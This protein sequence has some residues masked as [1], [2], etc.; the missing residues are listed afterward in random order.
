[1]SVGHPLPEELRA[2]IVRAF[3]DQSFTYDEIAELLGVGRATVNRIL[4]LHRETGALEPRPK[5]GGNV[6][7]ISGRVAKELRALV[8]ARPDSTLAELMLALKQRT[9]VVTSLSSM[10]RAMRRLGFSRKK[11]SSS[12]PSATRRTTSSADESSPRS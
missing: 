11:R 8:A 1:M 12:P 4:R 2:A 7:P 9:G 5:G 6:S 10:K 3:H